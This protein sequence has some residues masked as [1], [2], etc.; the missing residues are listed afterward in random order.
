MLINLSPTEQELFKACT[1]IAIGT[2]H[3]QF[4]E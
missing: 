2:D 3:N 4:L 1:M